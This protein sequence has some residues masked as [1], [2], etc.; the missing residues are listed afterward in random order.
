MAKVSVVSLGCPKNL[1]DTENLLSIL[2][3]EGFSRTG[4]EA[5]A[6]V[7]LINTCGFIEEA[8]RESIEE[9]LKLRNVKGEGKKLLVFGCL[10]KRHGEQLKKE[11]PEIDA[12]WGV[13]EEDKIAEYC[14]SLVISRKAGKPASRK[15]K[16]LQ[17]IDHRLSTFPYAYLKI[18][19]G[20]SR[21]CTYCVIPSIRG[22]FKSVE[23][24]RILKR[25]EEHVRSGSKE[26]VFVA[27]DLGSYGRELKGYRL[28]S[29]IR[30]IASISGDFW[31][32][33]LYLNPSSANDELLSVIADNKKVCKYLDIPLQH[34][35][36]RIL[37]LMGRSGTRK[38]Y[39]RTIGKIREAIPGI[40][41][42][43]TLMVGFPG[44]T[45]KDF[46]G[47]RNFV[48]EMRF[49]RLGVFTYSKEEG[50]P[51][52]GLKGGV[53]KKTMEKRRGEIMRIQS[54]ISLEK[55]MALV[56]KKFRTIIDEV[57]EDAAI[58]RLSS[59]AP[60]IDGVVI[61]EAD[62]GTRRNGDTKTGR[63]DERGKQRGTDADPA[64]KRSGVKE[65][66]RLRISASPRHFSLKVGE[67]V[68][69]RITEAYD[70]DLKGEVVG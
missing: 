41:L 43:T 31:I 70:Y 49:E 35:E 19:E 32:R 50:T 21:K 4:D 48:E 13:G 62:T 6:D 29:L 65:A 36:D 28:P 2:G 57:S 24:D 59:Q 34:S 68:N 3:R 54:R 44:E 22:P 66:P 18:A 61:I 8:K 39:A 17:T 52:A 16:N 58:A 15:A 42:R 47:L 26:L 9:I 7:L 67:F 25:A 60:E 40:T 27:Q 14:K 12:L 51:A 20:C 5:E 37:K 33:L 30:D 53:A 69:V 64:A 55:N 63:Y 38:S 56:G 45:E 10:A 1:V 23:P 11:I 46:A